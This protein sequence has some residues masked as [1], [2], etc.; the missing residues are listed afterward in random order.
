MLHAARIARRAI[1]DSSAASRRTAQSIDLRSHH[2][3]I[4]TRAAIGECG[5]SGPTHQHS[6]PSYSDVP[7]VVPR[8]GVVRQHSQTTSDA[9]GRRHSRRTSRDARAWT[10]RHLRSTHACPSASTPRSRR[11]RP[12]TRS[13]STSRIGVQYARRKGTQRVV[14]RLTTT[15]AVPALTRWARKR[16]ASRSSRSCHRFPDA[17]RQSGMEKR[18]YP[19]GVYPTNTSV[20]RRVRCPGDCAESPALVSRRTVPPDTSIA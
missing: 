16:T 6:I 9:I 5:G 12:T 7:S 19:A 10:T 3:T 17:L 20:C 8:I 15:R 4:Q 2:G 18:S 13:S 1:V 14:G 11:S